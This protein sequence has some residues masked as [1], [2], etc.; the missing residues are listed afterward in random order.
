MMNFKFLFFFICIINSILSYA[1]PFVHLE[2]FLGIGLGESK[3]SESAPSVR[4]RHDGYN[5][6]YAVGGRGGFSLG[7][8]ALGI[9]GSYGQQQ[10]EMTRSDNG[11]ATLDKSSYDLGMLVFEKGVFASFYLPK[12]YFLVE[13]FIDVDGRL[14]RSESDAANPFQ[15]NAKLSGEGFSL[16][17]G[18]K[19]GGLFNITLLYKKLEFDELPSTNNPVSPLTTGT[20]N[21]QLSHVF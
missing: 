7:P 21:L 9:T 12:I 3:F 15:K 10:V 8:L 1:I 4:Y 14:K 6:G 2:P 13:Y 11:V 16:G 18:F 20:L 19:T 5:I 17:L